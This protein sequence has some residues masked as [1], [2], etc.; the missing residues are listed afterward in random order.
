MYYN[1]KPTIICPIR[2]RENWLICSDASRFFFTSETEWTPLKE[3][4]LKDKN[5]NSTG[6]IDIV[7]VAHNKI[8]RN[9]RFWC[10]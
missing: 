8:R 3:I 2:F 1:G 6:N 4:R 5:G 10:N 7:L 9:L